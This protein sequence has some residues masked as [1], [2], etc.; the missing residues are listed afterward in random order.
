MSSILLKDAPPSLH[1]WLKSEALFNRRS[2]NQQIL[3]CLEWCMRSCG[4]ADF[5]DP[6]R[7]APSKISATTHAADLPGTGAEST[8]A[9]GAELA[10]RLSAVGVID[11]ETARRMN[12]DVSAH[13]KAK[14]RNFDYACFA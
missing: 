14:E 4:D 3:F 11:G 1:D 12:R 10:R 6:V 7:P 2:V 5:R 9:K 13:R 8:F